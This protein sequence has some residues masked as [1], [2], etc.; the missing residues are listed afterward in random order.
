MQ[1][2]LHNGN[3]N[4]L[5]AIE[6]NS[7]VLKQYNLP[8]CMY[9][10]YTLLLALLVVV[11]MQ[12]FIAYFWLFLKFFSYCTYT[13]FED[14][15]FPQKSFVMKPFYKSFFLNEFKYDLEHTWNPKHIYFIK[16]FQYKPF[17]CIKSKNKF[18]STL[19]TF[20]AMWLRIISNQD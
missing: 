14:N 8:I 11:F 3:I 2:T 17:F 13:N 5:V 9:I 16:P 12:C 19:N 7:I 1:C 4:S 10:R 18:M 20:R 15:I 6:F